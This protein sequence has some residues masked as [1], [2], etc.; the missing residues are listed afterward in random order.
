MIFTY[1][2]Q[3]HTHM[4][5][6]VNELLLLLQLMQERLRRLVSWAIITLVRQ[7]QKPKGTR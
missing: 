6:K 4:A 7:T 3:T 1:P 5:T 2:H